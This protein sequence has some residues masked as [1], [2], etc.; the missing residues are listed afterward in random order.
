MRAATERR[1]QIVRAIRASI[2]DRGVAPTIRELGQAV[3]LS[4]PSSVLYQ[5][6]RL[7]EQGIVRRTGR[8]WRSYGLSA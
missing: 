5:L 1:E 2:A 7:E 6:R 8:R 3:G 4:S